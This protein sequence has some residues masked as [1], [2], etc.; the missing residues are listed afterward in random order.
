MY[1]CHRM[2]WS[3]W[4]CRATWLLLHSHCGCTTVWQLWLSPE[5]PSTK[6][7]SGVSAL[8]FAT[9]QDS[10]R[11]KCCAWIFECICLEPA[12]IKTDLPELGLAGSDVFPWVKVSVLHIWVFLVL[13]CGSNTQWME[14]AWSVKLTHRVPDHI[15]TA[16]PLPDLNRHTQRCLTLFVQRCTW[17][18][19]LCINNLWATPTVSEAQCA[20][21]ITLR[22]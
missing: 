21:E 12:W 17:A 11:A 1:G 10:S 4:R 22:S 20:A 19:E 18:N 13:S 5:A 14:W 16:Q 9:A 15:K 2:P 7:H 3:F 6:S 8:C